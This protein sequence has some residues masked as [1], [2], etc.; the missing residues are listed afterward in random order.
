MKTLLVIFKNIPLKHREIEKLKV[1]LNNSLDWQNDILHNHTP[2]KGFKYRY[3]LVQFRSFENHAALFAVGEGVSFLLD[4]LSSDYLPEMFSSNYQI[5]KD[6]KAIQMVEKPLKYQLSHFIGFNKENFEKWKSLETLHEQ[7]NFLEQNIANHI[8][9]FCFEFGFTV[10]NKSLEVN[11]LKMKSTD[12]ISLK[13]NK[14]R[15]FEVIFKANIHLPEFLGLGRYK[16]MGY[17]ITSKISN[18]NQ[19][20]SENAKRIK[21]FKL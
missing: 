18:A 20:Q 5:F 13:S 10:P 14:M 17:G 19:T 7:I 2:E 21:T 15:C 4:L 6:N 1:A 9:N 8:L 16:S 12:G 11:I 3:P